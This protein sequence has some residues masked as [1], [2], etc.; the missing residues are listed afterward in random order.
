MKQESF[1]PILKNLE[2]GGVSFA[3]LK[4]PSSAQRFVSI[5]DTNL[6]SESDQ[7]LCSAGPRFALLLVIDFMKVCL[8]RYD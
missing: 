2:D 8:N 5:G 4:N 1:V 7:P 3:R 6:L